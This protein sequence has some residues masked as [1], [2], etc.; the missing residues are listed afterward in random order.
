MR[1][2]K[3]LEELM[4]EPEV[5]AALALAKTIDSGPPGFVLRGAGAVTY[6][7]DDE[8]KWDSRALDRLG[9]K[10]GEIGTVLVEVALYVQE[11]AG[12]ASDSDK[13]ECFEQVEPGGA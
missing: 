5:V 6:L 10:L 4:A 12:K 2:V 7:Y 1:E 8:G 3:S 13:P 11:H 9:K